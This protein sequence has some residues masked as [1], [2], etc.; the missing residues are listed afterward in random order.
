MTNVTPIDHI[1]T[2]PLSGV[3]PWLGGKHYLA[4][5]IVDRINAIPH[6][7]YAEPFTGMGGVFFRRNA[8]PA[9]EVVNDLN[10]DIVRLYRVLQR[11]PKAVFEILGVMPDSREEFQRLRDTDP[12]G[13]TD[14][15]R[16]ARLLY[17]QCLAFSG[18]VT[19]QVY[20]A[21][22]TKPGRLDFQRRRRLWWK[23]HRRLCKVSIESLDF[24]DFIQRYDSPK[25]L[26]YCDPPYWGREGYYG[27]DYF[28]REDFER[29][30]ANLN[31]IHGRF[32]LSLND[33]PEVRQLFDWATIE[34]VPITYRVK[35]LKT[36]ELLISN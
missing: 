35:S 3:A 36:H 6:T 25:T 8:R 5:R 4:S 7:C 33:H 9:V 29:L 32:I 28:K 23:I 14:V 27:K 16:A 17:L 21:G 1:P 2:E 18:K 26:F 19:S 10:G 15:E 20:A 24:G 12:N 30:A 13:L 22:S 31:S 34:T 11:H